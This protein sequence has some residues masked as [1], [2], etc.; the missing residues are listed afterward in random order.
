M[1]EGETEDEIKDEERMKMR[2]NEDSAS[3][4]DKQMK[5][6]IV[7]NIVRDVLVDAAR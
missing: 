7:R 4:L 5:G 2:M 6:M 1:K 3:K